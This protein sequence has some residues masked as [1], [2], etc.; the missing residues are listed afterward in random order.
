M[1]L[2]LIHS[3]FI[4]YEAKKKALKNAEPV[5]KGKEKDRMEECLVVF[6]AVEKIDENNILG[7][8]QKAFEE[9]KKDSAQVNTKNILLYP[10]AHLSPN[11]AKPDPAVKIMKKTE[12]LLKKITDK[13]EKTYASPAWIASIYGALGDFD[14]AFF[15]LEKAYSE[16]DNNL[17]QLKTDPK[18][19]PLRSYPRF[20]ALLK[21]MN[22]D[23]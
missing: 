9:I 23:Y 22:L 14:R 21:R 17:Q 5:A 13:S 3:N 19:D 2:L 8:A 12:E 18:L 7:A 10:Y 16:R 15:L 6:T 20:K 4:E 1:K 11:L